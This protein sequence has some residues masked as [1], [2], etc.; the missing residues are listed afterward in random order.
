MV[1]CGQ[2]PVDIVVRC[3]DGPRI[4]LL[5]GDLEVPQVDFAQC[6]DG[7][8]CVKVEPVEFLIVSGE[9]LDG[10]SDSLALD[11]A[12]VASRDP[13]GQKR[14]FGVIFEVSAAQRIALDVDARGEQDID[15]IFENLI[16][17]G[18]ADLLDKRWIPG[19]GEGG[20]DRELGAWAV[21]DPDSRRAVR[22]HDS[23]DAQP[24]YRVGCSGG[25]LYVESRVADSVEGFRS[26]AYQQGSLL[27]GCQFI[28]NL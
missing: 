11:S 2:C 12:D 9:M 7:N 14:I 23:R 5:D 19:G 18:P 10:C 6:P 24:F 4:A 28:D 13:A 8:P 17:Y 16:A 22:Q 25:T 21:V 27:L 26:A 15:S 3:H 1:L 20:S